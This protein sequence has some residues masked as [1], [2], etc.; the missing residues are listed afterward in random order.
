[1]KK[2]VDMLGAIWTGLTTHKLR[3]F[4][5]ILGVVLNRVNVYVVGYFPPYAAKRYFPAIGEI[6]MTAGLFSVLALL[7][8][9]F[10]IRFP[11]LSARA[12]ARRLAC[13][14]RRP[15]PAPR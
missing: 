4:L 13:M 2:V 11:V 3:S 8:R 10:A 9:F 5:T 15:I 7:Y 14:D 12:E 6:A 1:M